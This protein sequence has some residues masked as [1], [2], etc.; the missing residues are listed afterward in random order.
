MNDCYKVISEIG[1]LSEISEVAWHTIDDEPTEKAYVSVKDVDGREIEI[2][3]NNRFG[4]PI[5][6][7]CV[8]VSVLMGH[9]LQRVVFP[10]WQDIS[11]PIN[12]ARQKY[13]YT[14]ERWRN[15]AKSRMYDS[16]P[17]EYKF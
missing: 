6:M 17:P 2:I 14:G 3:M 10:W 9:I 5:L 16:I 8:L 4:E 7:N 13:P 11:K 1:K 12:E 15:E